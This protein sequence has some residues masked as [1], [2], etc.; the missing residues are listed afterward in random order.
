MAIPNN[1]ILEIKVGYV[2]N[3][4]QCYNVFHYK[5]EAEL[6]TADEIATQEWVIANQEGAGNGEIVGEFRKVMS[7]DV[8]INE[9]TA[10]WIFPVRFRVS[11]VTINVPGNIQ[12]V[13]DAQNVQG[14][15]TK[16]GNLGA[17]NNVGSMHI[18]GLP[19]NGYTGGFVAAGQLA[20]YATLKDFLAQEIDFGDV[21]TPVFP[22]ILN[23]TKTVV[24]GKD[25]YV[26]T[27]STLITGWE[28]QTEL[29]TQRTR[30]VGR[31]I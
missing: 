24:D 12:S 11:R 2:V 10:Q 18:G 27:G 5:T 30:T 3:T 26:V 23:K 31:G 17:R 13:C 9:L 14:T 1:A 28:V 29:R 21:Q 16:R 20:L 8:T 7:D 6:P 19:V 4:Q 15:L 25:K 22:S